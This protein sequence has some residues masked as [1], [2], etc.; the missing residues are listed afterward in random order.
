MR[1]ALGL[2]YDGNR[3]SGWQTQP[4]SHG[5]TT[6]QDCLERALSVIAD[7]P[8]E[9]VCAG[10]TDAGVHALQ[11]TV[12]FDTVA[13]RPLHAWLRGVNGHLPESM[14]VRWVHPVGSHF[15][16]RHSA[17]AR[18]YTYVL[19]SQAVRPVLAAQQ[20]GWT[21]LPLSLDAMQKAA[22]MLVGE[23]D[24]STFRASECQAKS[25]VRSVHSLQIEQR[26]QAFFITVTANA[27]L[28]HMVRN[29]MG[30]LVYVGSGR[31]SLAQFAAAFAAQDRQQGAPTFAA[32]G[33]YFCGALYPA[34]HCIPAPIR[35]TIENSWPW[36]V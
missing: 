3:F 21:H 13:Q 20:T 28:H 34:E 33:L 7:A 32:A 12:H 5:V 30:A 16:A 19:I 29:M 27:F 14:A 11:Q 15:H 4:S 23:H 22:Q 2:E 36:A 9:A 35:V 24:F 18:R 1:F 6:L 31:W 25:P 8:I 26:G 10:R 17:F